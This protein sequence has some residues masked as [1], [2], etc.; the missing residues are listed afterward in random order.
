MKNLLKSFSSLETP[1]Y[2]YDLELLKSTLSS[3]KQA[4]KNSYHVHY[5]LKANINARILDVIRQSGI[6]VDC[7]SGGEIKIAL[8]NGFSAN[9]IVL[10]GV[11]KTDSEIAYALEKDIFS[12]NIESLQELEVVNEI[13]NRHNKVARISMRINPEI[14]AGTHHYITTGTK[15]N[16]F[17]ISTDEMLNSIETIKSYNNIEFLGLHYH[18]GSQITDLNRFKVLAERVN[19]L[20]TKLIE[21]GFKLP[22][23]NVGGGLGIDYESPDQNPIPDFEAYFKIFN[24]HLKVMPG[25]EVHFELGRSI[26]G[27]CGTLISKVLYMKESGQTKFAIL[28]AG[29][30]ELMRPALYQAIHK[31]ENISSDLESEVYDIVGP[32]CESSDFFGKKT[33]LPKTKRGDI[34][35]IRSS[36]AYG[37]TMRSNYNGR[38]FAKAYYSEDLSH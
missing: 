15:D 4:N 3:L 30:T 28:D 19:L 29:M 22:H 1:F 13:A 17:G 2:Y 36:G 12:F 18:I 7:V 34:I 38:E 14:E 37:E 11:G 35:A 27:Q 20:H 16:K 21:Q 25:Q 23:L 24:D 33:P 5:A 10:A 31:I 6:G 26:V 9:Q 8:N 32:I